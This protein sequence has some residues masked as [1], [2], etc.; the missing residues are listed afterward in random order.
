MLLACAAAA[1]ASVD[2]RPYA[3]PDAFS[4]QEDALFT[5]PRSHGV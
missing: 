1:Y 2:H 3:N 4:T 5:V